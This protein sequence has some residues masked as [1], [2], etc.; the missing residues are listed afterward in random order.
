MRAG[1]SIRAG[2]R[3]RRGTVWR[4]GRPSSACSPWGG[5]AVTLGA[6]SA[7]EQSS[8]VL[9]ATSATAT[10]LTSSSCTLPAGGVQYP[11][12]VRLSGARTPVFE[13]APGTGLGAQTIDVRLIAPLAAPRSINLGVS[14]VGQP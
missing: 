1:T 11:T 14:L 13:A 4:C 6:P 7:T 3:P 8:P 5:W 12:A 10:C 9:V 2:D